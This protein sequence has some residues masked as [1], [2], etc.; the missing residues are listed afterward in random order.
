M[1]DDNRAGMYM[2]SS[3]PFDITRIFFAIKRE[4]KVVF[5]SVGIAL[6]IAVALVLLLPKKYTAESLLLLDRMNSKAVSELYQTATADFSQP[7][8]ESEVEILLSRSVAEQLLGIVQLPYA[9][10]QEKNKLIDDVLSNVSVKQRALTYVIS[11]AYSDPDPQKAAFYANAYAQAYIQNK[12]TVSTNIA[13]QSNDWIDKELDALK[14]K[15]Q[16]AHAN[17]INYRKEH[18]LVTVLGRDIS[19]QRL[20]DVMRILSD[21]KLSRATAKAQYDESQRI[22][23]KNAV[24]D[25]V[26]QSFSNEVTNNIRLRYIDRNKQYH[27]LLNQY[28]AEHSAVKKLRKEIIEYE[29]MILAEMR[30]VSKEQFKEYQV[31]LAREQEIEQQLQDS[32]NTN[33]SSDS[34]TLEL[35]NLEKKAQ[36]YQKLYE[37]YLTKYENFSKEQILPSTAA[38][39]ISSAAVP[40]SPSHPKTLLIL[41]A[42]LLFGGGLG[43]ILAIIRDDR[44][45]TFRRGGQ[46]VHELSL[47]FSGYIPHT[48]SVCSLDDMRSLDY[49]KALDE[50]L[51]HGIEH[52][53]VD[54]LKN[55][56]PQHN[57]VG[58]TSSIQQSGKTFCSLGLAHYFGAVRKRTLVLTS[59]PF[60]D[61]PAGNMITLNPYLTCCVLDLQS[62]IV[63]QEVIES[64]PTHSA[65]YD[66]IIIDFPSLGRSTV[67]SLLFGHVDHYIMVEAWGKSLGSQLLFHLEN[68]TTM[69]HDKI[70]GVCLNKADLRRLEREF[71]YRV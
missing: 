68:S 16:E 18:N 57:I 47:H 45:K 61:M 71:G 17:W 2:H 12:L 23:A 33:I 63:T 8:V 15:A 39:L 41:V 27:N 32:I 26:S 69:T 19:E 46:I 38:R 65:A 64:L 52:S 56:S 35:N 1:S 11:I 21:A 60:A 25:A 44:N 70:R 48:T 14:A 50:N 58:I 43:V 42:A 66:L 67:A 30:R 53:A 34:K 22:I 62:P 36:T 20:D 51:H 49:Y 31:A 55:L 37:E 28:G 4:R 54:I 10:E 13:S 40:I 6:L 29:S 59:H 3:D 24:H 5:L 7:S 9:D